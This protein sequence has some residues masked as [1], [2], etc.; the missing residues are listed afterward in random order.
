MWAI[1]ERDEKYNCCFS[2]FR[3]DSLRKHQTTVRGPESE[4]PHNLRTYAHT[5]MKTHFS[6]TPL[7][8]Y[9]CQ[10]CFFSEEKNSLGLPVLFSVVGHWTPHTLRLQLDRQQK[11]PLILAAWRGPCVLTSVHQ[12]TSVNRLLHFSCSLRPCFNQGYVGS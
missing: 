11:K 10:R 8:V 7:Q 3:N 4:T 12:N 5:S 1:I 6:T 9:Y 2:Y